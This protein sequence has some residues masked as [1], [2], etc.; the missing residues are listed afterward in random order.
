MEF[1]EIIRFDVVIIRLYKATLRYKIF[2]RRLCRVFCFCNPNKSF[3][4]GNQ[5]WEDHVEQIKSN[6]SEKTSGDNFNLVHCNSEDTIVFFFNAYLWN[7]IVT[8]F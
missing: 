5:I 8:Y 1:F 6:L 7:K 2:F 3:D 4:L